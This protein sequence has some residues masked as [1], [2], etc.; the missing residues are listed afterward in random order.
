[1]KKRLFLLPLLAGLALCSC[2]G[3][4]NPDDPKGEDFPGLTL[5]IDTLKEES[6]DGKGYAALADVDE[7]NGVGVGFAEVM[8]NGLNS[9]SLPKWD[10][11]D[12]EVVDVIQFSKVDGENG[13]EGGSITVQGK[14]SKLTVNVYSSREWSDTGFPKV[15][16]DGKTVK[17]PS[18]AAQTKDT[19]YKSW[20]SKGTQEFDLKI[21]TVEYA[22]NAGDEGELVI[23]N[24]NTYALYFDSFI[25][26]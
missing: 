25:L 12:D 3:G 17:K 8:V 9:E 24:A 23:H 20:N 21:F 10:T 22:V 15:T 19:E 2:G 6:G 1:M 11:P 18:K 14:I 13:R 26:E 7:I 4:D 5:D 16:F